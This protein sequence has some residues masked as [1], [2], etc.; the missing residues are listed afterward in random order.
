[1][2]LAGGLGLSAEVGGGAGTG[3][4]AADNGLEEGLEDD[5]GTA[6]ELVSHLH[7]LGSREC[8]ILGLG[9]GHPKDQDKLEDIVEGCS[10][11]STL[12][13]ILRSRGYL[14]NQ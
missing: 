14:R 13:I 1:V 11:V 6:V 5:L 3:E 4:E 10:M 8:N 2:G 7:S 12:A 9:E